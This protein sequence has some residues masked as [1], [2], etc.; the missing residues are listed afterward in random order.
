M[1]EDRRETVLA[2]PSLEVQ[3]NVGDMLM[4]RNLSVRSV[5][6]RGLSLVAS[7]EGQGQINIQGY[8]ISPPSSVA[9]P[10]SG[11]DDS[12]APADVVTAPDEGGEIS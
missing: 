11:S 12:V 6:L 2:L 1:S 10:V 9:A 8:E 4:Q 7:Y 5:K 3:L